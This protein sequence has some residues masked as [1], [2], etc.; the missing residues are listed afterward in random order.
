MITERRKENLNENGDWRE[1]EP[2]ENSV[3]SS[4]NHD[5]ALEAEET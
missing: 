5:T 3:N 4:L 1:I 2:K